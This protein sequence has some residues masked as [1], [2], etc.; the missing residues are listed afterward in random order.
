MLRGRFG[1]T[2]GAPYI[3]GSLTLPQQALQVDISFLVDTGAD[4]TMIMPTDGQVVGIDYSQLSTWTE[5]RGI[6]GARTQTYEEPALLAFK[7]GSHLLHVY[8]INVLILR[9]TNRNLG[10]PSLLGRDIIDRWHM[11]YDK[12]NPRPRLHFR[13]LS[14]DQT[15]QY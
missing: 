7:E 6:D 14:S 13:V 10:I 3:E 15:I 8:S 5:V 1:D 4:R 11:V 2:S 9:P 12:G